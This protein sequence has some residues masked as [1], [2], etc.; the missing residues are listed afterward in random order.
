M[1]L[2]DTPGLSTSEMQAKFEQ[3]AREVLVPKFNQ[4]VD[5]LLGPSAASQIGAKGKNRTVQGHIDNLENPHNVTAEQV[6][7]YTKDQ[8]EKAISDRISQIGSADMTQATYDPNHRQQDIFAY[9]DSRG[10]STYT[11]TKM[12]N[13]HHFNGSGTS[14]RAKMTADVE[15][16]DTVMLGGKEVPAYVGAETFAD[17]LAGESV[18]GRWLTFTQD[19]TQ[20]NFNGGGGLSN[21]KLALATADTGDVISGKKFYSGDKTLKT[22]EILPRNTVGQNGTVGISQYF[23]E[24]AVSK[25]NSNNTQTNNNLDGVSRLCLQPPAGFYDGNSYVGETFAKVASAIGLT[26]GKLCAGNTVLGVNGAG[27][28]KA[29]WN[30]SIPNDT[31]THSL[32][33]TPAAGTLLF[34]F[35][36]NADHDMQIKSITIGSKVVATPGRNNMYFATFSVSA[37]QNIYMQW[38][39]NFGGG[40]PSGHGVICYV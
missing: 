28:T 25:A 26:A 17:A 14:G 22:G 23:S 29:V 32:A 24:V 7:A 11:H 6:G 16:G 39:S 34:F 18:T 8:T 1:G 20:I 40:K 12:D 38:D 27:V 5:E 36:G 9:A 19:G 21:T 35:A 3:I 30:G 2:P 15:A 31:S 13:V 37:N 10:V 4:L 33:T